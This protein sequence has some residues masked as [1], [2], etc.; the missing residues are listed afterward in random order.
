MA[1]VPPVSAAENS[2]L[3]TALD[4]ILRT[5]WARY[6]HIATWALGLVVTSGPGLAVAWCAVTMAMGYGRGLVE[7]AMARD[8]RAKTGRDWSDVYPWV[9]AGVGVFWAAA[10]LM[11]WRSGHEAGPALAVLML[12]AGYLMVLTQFR[13]A[14]RAAVI[15]S[16]PYSAVF[17]YF[18]AS[19]WGTPWFAATLAGIPILASALGFGLMHGLIAQN[20]I[21]RAQQAAERERARLA[22][23]MDSAQAIVWEIDRDAGELIGDEKLW[24]L[25]GVRSTY[26]DFTGRRLDHIHPDDRTAT[27]Q[28]FAAAVATPS[29]RRLTHRVLHPGGDEIWL[30][31]A[32]ESFAGP[33]GRVSRITVMTMDVT[34]EKRRDAALTRLSVERDA[35][36]AANAAKSQ[37]LANMSHELRT[38][39]NAIIGY[40]ELLREDASARADA[41]AQRD[42]EKVLGAG[43]RLLQ[44]I[45]DVLDLSKIEAG[46]LDLEFGAVDLAAILAEGVD[47]IRPLAEANGN[48]VTTTI[49]DV[50]AVVSDGFR[51]GQCVLNLL[52]N[53]AK[54]TINGRID[55]RVGREPSPAGDMIRIDVADTG[56]G[57]SEAQIAR[58]FQPFSQADASIT[59]KFGGTGLGLAI[60]RRIA[61]SLGGDV[62]VVS[63]PGRGATFTLRIAAAPP[64]VEPDAG[65]RGEGPIVLVID[66][67][68]AARDLARRALSRRGYAVHGVADAASGRRFLATHRVHA[69]VLDINLPDMSGWVLLELLKADPATR[70]APVI[71]M[72]VDD[73]RARSLGLGA[74]AHVT[75]PADFD[76]LVA[77]IARC[78]P[79]ELR[80]T[81]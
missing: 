4:S 24:A 67:D 46:K 52:S 14:P 13:G 48:T 2:A 69:V 7:G 63:A 55:V 58:L 37:F 65:E 5:Q 45:N 60:T 35:A 61:Q 64:A 66:D 49:A 12:S 80:A 20:R 17:L 11:A 53:A 40:S 44:L 56:E 51:I 39:L 18:V 23:A 29:R 1:G 75:K 32:I 71:V 47:T 76:V 73:D 27:E 6:V 16:A 57:L 30:S 72:S 62:T 68:P 34:D 28:A 36:E 19:A 22:L 74:L 41:E 38:P 15:V 25:L 31:H 8:E 70:E 10:P 81:A 3:A 9:A 26:A 77:A 43:R 54:F 79:L 21:V 59:R 50:G 78:A 42:L 33:G